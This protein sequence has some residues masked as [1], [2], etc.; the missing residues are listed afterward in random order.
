MAS[1]LPGPELRDLGPD[2][3]A[4]TSKFWILNYYFKIINSTYFKGV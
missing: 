2:I 1:K 3:N 4:K